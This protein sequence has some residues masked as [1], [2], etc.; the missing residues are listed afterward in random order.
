[1]SRDLDSK[2]VEAAGPNAKLL[3]KNGTDAFESSTIDAEL[4]A[5]ER[6]TIVL[7]GCSKYCCAL[8]TAKSALKRDYNVMTS[9]R[10]LLGGIEHYSQFLEY[11][12]IYLKRTEYYFTLWGLIKALKSAETDN[13][14]L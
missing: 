2:I 9:D 8:A 5:F 1:M 6:N 10:L 11:I 4:K 3:V 7:A 12:K 13:T 14:K